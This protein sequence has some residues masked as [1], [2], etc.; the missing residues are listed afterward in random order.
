[1]GPVIHILGAELMY[2]HEQFADKR[3]E[4]IATWHGIFVQHRLT[5]VVHPAALRELGD[6]HTPVDSKDFPPMV[7]GV[8]NDVNFPVVAVPAGRNATDGSPVSMQIVGTPYTDTGLLQLAIDYQSTTEH[9]REQ[10]PGLDTAPTYQSPER[11]EEGRTQTP[12][13]TKA[14][15]ADPLIPVRQSGVDPI[16]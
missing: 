16:W 12:F 11:K 4:H 5:A 6:P 14:S 9:H 2:I 10:P 8:W 7:F 13:G 1:V 15:P 3:A